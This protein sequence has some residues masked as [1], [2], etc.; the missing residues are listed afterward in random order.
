MSPAAQ[1]DAQGV[2]VGDPDDVAG[3]AVGPL[4]LLGLVL[5]LGLG[6]AGVGELL[7]RRVAPT[8]ARA[9]VG[10]ARDAV[11]VVVEAVRVTC[12]GIQ[13][14]VLGGG[15]AGEVAAVAVDDGGRRRLDRDA[16]AQGDDGERERADELVV[17]VFPHGS[18]RC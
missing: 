2:T 8:D 10:L 9:G 15:L 11:A 7:R 3:L 4:A 14:E 13:V 12:A 18:P 6:G 5:G 16:E 17:H 1:T